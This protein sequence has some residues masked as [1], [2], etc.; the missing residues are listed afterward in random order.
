[1]TLDYVIAQSC[2][3]GQ[4]NVLYLLSVTVLNNIYF[5]IY[6]NKNQAVTE[7]SAKC[8]T[9]HFILVFKIN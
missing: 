9:D 6:S 3:K 8:V 5:C 1:M 7:L 2:R 4:I